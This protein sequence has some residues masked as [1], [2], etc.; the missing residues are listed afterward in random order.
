MTSNTDVSARPQKVTL[1]VRLL[2]FIVAIGVLRT[3]MTV[4]RHIEVRSP[5]FLIASKA[6]FYAVSIFVIYQMGKGKNWARWALVGLFVVHVPLT[7]LPAFE[8]FVTNP[9]NIG[10]AFLQLAMYLASLALLFQKSSSEWFS[11]GGR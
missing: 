10:L 7:L 5:D 8:S 9:L 11:S 3:G 4:M 2:Y 1:A 6:L